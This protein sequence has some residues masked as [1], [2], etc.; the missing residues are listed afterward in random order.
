[1]GIL[2]RIRTATSFG[3]HPPR[4]LRRESEA[5]L[6]QELSRTTCWRRLWRIARDAGCEDAG[7]P[8]YRAAA[9]SIWD[10]G[11]WDPTPRPGAARLIRTD[12]GR[13]HGCSVRGAQASL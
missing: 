12:R 5:G 10:K 9:P 1:M 6:G 4:C 3:H 8:P 2:I 7:L 11:R 13:L